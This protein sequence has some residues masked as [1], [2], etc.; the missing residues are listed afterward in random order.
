MRLILKIIDILSVNEKL[1]INEISTQLKET[2]SFVNKVTNKLI[3]DNIIIK[4]TIGNSHLCTLNLNNEKTQAYLTLNEIE[5]KERFIEK[6]KNIRTLISE[7]TKKIQAECVLIFG[8]Y[9]KGNQTKSS[10][11]DLLIINNKKDNTINKEINLLETMYNIKINQ[12]VINERIFKEMIQ[13]NVEINVGKEALKNHIIL[14]GSNIFWK[15]IC[16][17]KC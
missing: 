10:D 1:T 5:K 3:K 4:Q 13:N 2:Y 6:N 16:E 15:L 9:A 7:I 12:I 11:I 17:A 14:Y 8:S